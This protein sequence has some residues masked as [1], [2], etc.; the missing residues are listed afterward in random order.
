MS[1][2]NGSKWIRPEKRH[3]IYLRDGLACAY[4][5]ATNEEAVLSLDHLRPVS[6]GGDNKASN[7]VT[8]C[9]KCNRSRGVRSVTEFAK[10]VAGYL[11]HG[12]TAEGIM[13]H[14]RNCR[15]RKIDIRAAK[16]II[17]RRNEELAR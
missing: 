10:S 9:V 16:E 12:V 13:Q 1:N 17:A 11:N 7:L 15:R 2:K 6:K 4:C 5:G 8:C 14:I 3:A